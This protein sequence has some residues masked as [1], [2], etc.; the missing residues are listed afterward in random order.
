MGD[1]RSHAELCKVSRNC[2][3][4]RMVARSFRRRRFLVVALAFL[5]WR[6][7][8]GSV[9]ATISQAHAAVYE[10]ANLEFARAAFFKPAEAD[11]AGLPFGLAPLLLQESSQTNGLRP[12][13]QPGT[14]ILRKDVLAVDST[15][16]EVFVQVDSVRLN[17]RSHARFSYSWFYS[18]MAVQGVRLTL[19]T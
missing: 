12:T 5:A 1:G 18:P 11:S 9:P 15:R 17:G 10:Q 14:L 19:S 16:P 2:Q 4:T 13:D 8:A 7:T 6:V 3:V